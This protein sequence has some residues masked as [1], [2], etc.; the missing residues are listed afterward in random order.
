MFVFDRFK[1]LINNS[2]EDTK[3]KRSP[4]T[5]TTRNIK[6]KKRRKIAKI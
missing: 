3:T 5:T 6:I 1:E 2:N 4:I